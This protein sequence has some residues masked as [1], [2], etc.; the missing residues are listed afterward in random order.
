M[1]SGEE[2]MLKT[3]STLV[4][5]LLPAVALGQ[6]LAPAPVEGGSISVEAIGGS[7]DAGAFGRHGQELRINGWQAGEDLEGLF[8]EAEAEGGARLVLGPSVGWRLGHAR[9][10]TLFGGWIHAATQN[11]PLRPGYAENRD[12]VMVRLGLRLGE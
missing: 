1:A 10:L 4:A 2:A 6:V 5:T 3:L 11:T 12:G 8:E 7:R 9:E